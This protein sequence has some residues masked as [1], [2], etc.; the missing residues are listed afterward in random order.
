MSPRLTTV[1]VGPRRLRRLRARDGA[2][3]TSAALDRATW[4]I[5]RPVAGSILANVRPSAARARPAPPT[6]F[7]N[8]RRGIAATGRCDRRSPRG[9]AAVDPQLVAGDVRRGAATPGTPAAPSGPRPRP[10]GRSGTRAPY[11]ALNCS[12]CPASTP[13]GDSVFTRTPRPAQ[14][15]AKNF[16]R[17]TTPAFEAP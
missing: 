1:V 13:P 11:L 3:A 8:R 9:E 6:R 2:R 14:C 15:V 4:Q 16:D 5:S 12:S 10:C 7:G 17:L